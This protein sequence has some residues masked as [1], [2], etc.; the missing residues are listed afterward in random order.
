[1][2]SSPAPAL[3]L[4]LLAACASTSSAGSAPGSLADLDGTAWR[5]SLIDGAAPVSDRTT[6]SFSREGLGANVGCNGIGGEWT[7][8]DGH[9]LAPNLM[10]TEMYCEGPVWDQERA[11]SQILTSRPVIERTGDSLTLRIDGHW[12]QLVRAGR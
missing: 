2:R 6:L 4:F 1:M 9:L 5:F 11:V 8:K 7:V 3:A 12:A 10:Q